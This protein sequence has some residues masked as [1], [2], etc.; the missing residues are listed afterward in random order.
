MELGWTLDGRWGFQDVHLLEL[1]LAEERLPE[2]SELW[3]LLLDLL[4][5]MELESLG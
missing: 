1:L 2:L 4:S 5:G 3:V